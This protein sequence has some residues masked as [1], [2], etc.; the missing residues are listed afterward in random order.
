MGTYVNSE[1]E[2]A[3]NKMSRVTEDL[4]SSLAK[5]FEISP[6]QRWF[7][8]LATYYNSLQSLMIFI[9]PSSYEILI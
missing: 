6:V 7:S 1:A 5:T 8:S 2:V 9:Y 4:V 3:T